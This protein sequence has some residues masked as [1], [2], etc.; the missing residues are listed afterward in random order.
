MEKLKEMLEERKQYLLQV[1][2]EKEQALKDT[3][4]GS[5]RIS[6]RR[7]KIMYYHRTN[8]KNFNGTY[9]REQDQE[10]ARKLAQKDYD[11]KILANVEK[12]LNATEKYLVAT[13]VLNT[14]QIYENMHKERQKLVTPI[15][16]P[17]DKFVQAWQQE[18]YI[19]KEFAE[20]IPEF[21]TEK[22]ERVRS[23]SEVIIM[24]KTS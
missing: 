22:G 13:R 12:E 15:W 8:P 2:K 4:D 14:K 1:K 16:V 5:L 7:G 20:G 17:D 9:I 10:L 18:E 6:S 24:E 3:P 11:Q 21:F 23:K 19:G